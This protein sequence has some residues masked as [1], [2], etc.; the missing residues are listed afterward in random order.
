MQN[1]W[2][3][4]RAT[5]PFDTAGVVARINHAAA[6]IRSSGGTVIFVQHEA[7]DAI[8]GSQPWEII[9]TL[10]TAAN[11]L[12]VGK[13]A[14]DPCADTDFLQKLAHAGGATVYVCGFATEFCVDSAV[15]ATASRAMDLVVLSDA[16]TTSNRPHLDAQG[17]IAHHNWIWSN[18]AVPASS[19]LAVRTVAEA[20]PL[21]PG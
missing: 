5:L 8:A 21:T 1:A 10:D 18:M 12:T 19:T 9:P 4:N 16:H 2:L 11:D 13:R 6:C 20:F 14:C 17:I 3:A 7:E 15:R